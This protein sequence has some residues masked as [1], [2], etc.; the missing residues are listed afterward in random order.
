MLFASLIFGN[1]IV[2][3][4]VADDVPQILENTTVQSL[5]NIYVPFL[6]DTRSFG[7]NPTLGPSFYR[8]L[9]SLVFSLIYAISQKDVYLYHIIQIILVAINA[10]LVY[11]LFSSFLKK[12]LSFLLSFIFLIH[13]INSEIAYYIADTQDALFFFFGISALL[14][15][16]KFQSKKS[17]IFS[18]VLLF[19]CLLS[20]ES[21]ILFIFIA[22]FYKLFLKRNNLSQF[23]TALFLLFSAYFTLRV[24]AVGLSISASL[25]KSPIQKAPFLIR[26]FNIP[27]IFFYYVKTF[28]FPLKLSMSYHWVSY[29][30]NSQ[31]IISFFLDFLC[32]SFFLYI[33][34]KLDH[35]KSKTSKM[36]LFF[37]TWFFI[38][39]FFHLHIIALDQTVAE[40]WF[41]FSAVGL[42]GIIGIILENFNFSLR[43]KWAIL[44]IIIIFSLL[45]FQSFRRS[46]DWR[47]DKTIATHDLKTSAEA[48]VLE[49]ELTY[50]YYKE[51]NYLEAKN[52]ALRS[53]KI[54]P[55]VVN[56]TNLGVSEFLLGNYKDSEKAYVQ[57]LKL[58][59]Y[60][61]TYH[62]LS[63]LYLIYGNPEKNVQFLKHAVKKYPKDSFLFLVL[64]RLEYFLEM[65]KEAKDDIRHAYLIDSSSRIKY[66]YDEMLQDKPLILKRVAEE[67]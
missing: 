38:G 45:S 14:T 41:Y 9:P 60:N 23:F 48:Y 35:R 53:I 22:S 21:G 20:K 8:P 28:F 17:I 65:K 12:S 52:H 67:N 31:F 3:E 64:A 6:K 26:I 56:Y 18:A 55:N 40:R 7:E 51:S 4:F 10:S 25:L 50:V 36:Y 39:I 61:L 5:K 32:I 33:F 47:D 49:D 66:F 30:I 59:D 16:H 57:A 2:N 43:N 46:F 54:Y 29:H 1:G 19:F 37:S 62:N 13:P 24:H 63:S 58:G 44:I 34:K 27:E 11:V 15:L 42:L